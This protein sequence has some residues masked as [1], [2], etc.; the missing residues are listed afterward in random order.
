MR[1][2][3]FLL[4]IVCFSFSANA[5]QLVGKW[6]TI[7]DETGKAKS[8][9]QIYEQNGKYYGKIIELLLPEDKGKLCD[10]CSGNNKNKP[11][12]GMVIME[13]MSKDGDSFS[14]GKIMDPKSGKTYKCSIEFDGKDA[15]KVRGFIG[16]SLIGRTQTWKR[17]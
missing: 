3:F 12:E 17:A 4:M 8:I 5:Q 14:G 2:L 13:E 15:L 11:I 7:D 9:I 10:K 16:I 6:K 1:S